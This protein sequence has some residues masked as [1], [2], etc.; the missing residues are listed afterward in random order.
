MSDSTLQWP[1]H[2]D[3]YHSLILTYKCSAINT[4][5]DSQAGTSSGDREDHPSSQLTPE[6]SIKMLFYSFSVEKS[7]FLGIFTIWYWCCWCACRCHLVSTPAQCLYWSSLK[8]LPPILSLDLSKYR[9]NGFCFPPSDIHLNRSQSGQALKTRSLS[10]IFHLDAA[11]L[12][13]VMILISLDLFVVFIV[14]K[15]ILAYNQLLYCCHS[16]ARYIGPVLW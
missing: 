13:L 11:C 10:N 9:G 12:G 7:N 3:K 1:G 4:C 6:S 2:I 8:Y 5:F 14:L 15:T 16:Q